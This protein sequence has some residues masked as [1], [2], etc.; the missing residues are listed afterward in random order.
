MKMKMN[1]VKSIA[2]RTPWIAEVP[3]L[4]GLV[5]YERTRTEAISR[6]QHLA[7]RVIA[8]R[9]RSRE[10]IP[11]IAR[12]FPGDACESNGLRQR[13]GGFGFPSANRWTSKGKADFA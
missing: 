7:L 3:D 2:R 1:I 4:P 10:K 11:E 6:V 12:H 5:T 8:D 9:P 13:R